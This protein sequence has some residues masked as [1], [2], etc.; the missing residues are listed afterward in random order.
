LEHKLQVYWRETRRG[1]GRAEEIVMTGKTAGAESETAGIGTGAGAERGTGIGG[2]ITGV[3]IEIK[4][5]IMTGKETTTE[6]GIVIDTDNV[7]G[8]ML[9]LAWMHEFASLVS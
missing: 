8:N 5:M 1:A 6:I 3:E 9:G 2:G 7:A 4:I